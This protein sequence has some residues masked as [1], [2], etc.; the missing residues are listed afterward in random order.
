MVGLA[1]RQKEFCAEYGKKP[2][3]TWDFDYGIYTHSACK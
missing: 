1:E 2:V 3:I